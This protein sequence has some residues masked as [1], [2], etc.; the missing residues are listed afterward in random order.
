[1]IAVGLIVCLVVVLHGVALELL[2][3]WFIVPTFG[4][5]GI[6]LAQAIGIV[7]A[8]ALLTLQ[9]IP[10]DED[11]KKEALA[12]DTFVPVFAIVVGWVVH[13]FM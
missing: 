2:W 11:A 1:M 12:F 5:P 3:G 8:F 7:I 9:H 13:L 6:S 4:L 10:R